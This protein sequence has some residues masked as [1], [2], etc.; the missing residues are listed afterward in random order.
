MKMEDM[1]SYLGKILGGRYEVTELVGVGGMAVVYKAY[2]RLEDRIV[3]VKILKEEFLANSDYIRRFKNESKAIAMLSHPNIVSVYDVDYGERLQYI[4]M[5]YV[6]GITLNEYIEQVKQVTV[7]DALHFV[8]EILRAL[9]HAHDRGIIHR[10]IK[11][12]N[13]IILKDGSIKVTDFGIASLNKSEKKDTAKNTIGSVHYFSPEQARGQ[14]TDERSDIYSVGVVLYEMLTGRLPFQAENSVSVAIMQV[15][16]EP[17]RPSKF[18]PAINIGLEQI[19]LKAMN[20]DPEKRYQS[21]AGMLLDISDYK[22]NPDAEFGYGIPEDKSPT[23]HVDLIFDES[24]TEKGNVKTP[25]Y[26]NKISEEKVPHR[27]LPI[28]VGLLAGLLML[29]VVVL[30]ALA[31]FTD[32]FSESKLTV[33]NFV[34]KDYMTEVKNSKEFSEFLILAEEVQNNQYESGII[35]QQ[36]PPYGTRIKRDRQVTL[37]VAVGTKMETIPNVNNHDFAE[38]KKTLEQLGFVVEGVAES[39]QLKFGTVIRTS[40]EQGTQAPQNSTVFVYYASD[41]NLIEVPLLVGWTVEDAKRLL[42]SMNLSLDEN[43]SYENSDQPEGTIIKQSPEEKLKVTANSKVSVTLSTGIAANSTANVS[44]KLPSRP[45]GTTGA[46]M[47]TLNND[48]I[49]EKNVLLDGDTYSMEVVGSGANNTLKVFVDSKMIY[50]CKIDFSTK[51]AS[52][53]D[54]KVY[55]IPT[56]A[57]LPNVVGKDKDDAV[58]RLNNAGFTNIV[59]VEKTVVN[60]LNVGKVQNQIP[61][62]SAFSSRPLDTVITL[63]VGVSP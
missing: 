61:G 53:K 26:A 24:L 59:I 63:E 46:L 44:F 42:E 57:I 50:S 37:K 47:V 15:N 14:N 49:G 29:A 30:G 36:D 23:K 16:S 13:I 17:E 45:G 48:V 12:H 35:F 38:V 11:P 60:P 3:A 10:D 39:S 33:P 9:Q 2:D 52:I 43:F 25:Q 20:K 21:A 54:E 51:P 27:K 18:S 8:T 22:R 31:L 58:A 32:V 55:D 19:I 41:E 34:G 62:H 40:P 6:E 28:F 5:E 4:V 56:S 1:R 7:P